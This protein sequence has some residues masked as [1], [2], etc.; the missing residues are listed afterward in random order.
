M[1]ICWE[2]PSEIKGL[3]AGNRALIYE[4]SGSPETIRHA[5]ALRGEEIVRSHWQQWECGRNAHIS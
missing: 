2:V 1:T 4:S 5:P 3:S